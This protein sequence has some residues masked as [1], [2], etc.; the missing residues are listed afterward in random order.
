M[1]AQD[2]HDDDVHFFDGPGFE[3]GNGAVPRWFLAMMGII[4]IVF[5][6][7]LGVYLVGAQPN[8]ARIVDDRPASH[9]AEGATTAP[10]E[11]APASA[12]APDA[13]KDAA[14]KDKEAPPV[15]KDAEEAD[16]E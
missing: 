16:D 9:A 2:A 1:S 5:I 14:P 7:Y 13:A 11:V 10:K 8:T 15:E 4:F 6:A 3:E 12:G